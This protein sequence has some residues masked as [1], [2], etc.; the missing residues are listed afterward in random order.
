[1]SYEDWLQRKADE[2]AHNEIL[3]FLTVVAGIN[4]S[5]GGLI[6]TI[7]ILGGPNFLLFL[8]Q[9]PITVSVALG[10][11]LTFLGF[12]IAA[13]GFV[14]TFYHSR[15]RSWYLGEVQKSNIFEKKKDESKTAKEVLEE[16][17]RGQSS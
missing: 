11:I 5:M 1:M 7:M 15:K 14:L 8:T 13:S 2:S 4:I 9:Q 3:S 17:A 6:V 12:I 16:Y 10:P